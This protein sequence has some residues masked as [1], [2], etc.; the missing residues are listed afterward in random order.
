VGGKSAAHLAIDQA[1]L[2]VLER[3]A[4]RLAETLPE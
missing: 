2:P 1:F 3:A 4:Q